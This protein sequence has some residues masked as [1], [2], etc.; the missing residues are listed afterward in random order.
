LALGKL[1]LFVTQTKNK[2]HALQILLF[3]H[4][5]G[6]NNIKN[7]NVLQEKTSDAGRKKY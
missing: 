1:P 4:N 6:E 2:S 3:L 7:K 5:K